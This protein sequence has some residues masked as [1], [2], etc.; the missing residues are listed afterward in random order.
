LKPE[1]FEVLRKRRNSVLLEVCML[2]MLL[3]VK[4]YILVKA[5]VLAVPLIP[6]GL[7]VDHDGAPG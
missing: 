6:K 1:G 3:T 5:E 2:V 4:V 7:Q